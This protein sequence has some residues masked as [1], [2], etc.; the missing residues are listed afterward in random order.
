MTQ[1]DMK[2]LLQRDESLEI[3]I[4]GDAR[5][6][7]WFVCPEC[8]GAVDQWDRFCKHCGQRLKYGS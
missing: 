3:E 7:W 6:S 8:H 1:E 2:K 5:S 4:E